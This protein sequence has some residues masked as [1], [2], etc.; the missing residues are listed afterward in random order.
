MSKTRP[1][2]ILKL[3]YQQKNKSL[4]WTELDQTKLVQFNLRTVSHNLFSVWF[5]FFFNTP[6]CLINIS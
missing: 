4:N 6:A 1:S 5:D 3:F 2:W